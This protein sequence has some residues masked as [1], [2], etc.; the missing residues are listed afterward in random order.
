MARREFDEATLKKAFGSL[1]SG[2]MIVTAGDGGQPAG[3]TASSCTSVSLAPP[4]LLFCI[5]RASENLGM[6]RAAGGFAVNVLAEG[7]Q[8][9]ATRFSVATDDRFEGVD[10]RWSAGGSPLIAG[11]VSHFDCETA[12]IVEAGDHLVFIGTVT[13]LALGDGDS[14]G[15]YR[16][17]YLGLE[18]GLAG[19]RRG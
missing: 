3:F 1:P 19:L 13:G 4:M 15:Y 8:D 14:L 16:G 11:A 6:Y 9:L 10:W 5:N 17:Q 12:D 7:Q 2:V 18:S